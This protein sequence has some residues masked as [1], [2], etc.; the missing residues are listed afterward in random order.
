MFWASLAH[1]QGTYNYTKQL[2]N[3]KQLL[4]ITVCSFKQLLCTTVWSL[5]MGQ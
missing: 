4:C 1:H 5:M 2:L 3:V